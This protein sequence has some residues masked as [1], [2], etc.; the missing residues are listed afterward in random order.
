ML[1]M[2]YFPK[3]TPDPIRKTP[4]LCL[5]NQ[6]R[7]P[8]PPRTSFHAKKWAL[9]SQGNGVPA[10]CR[11]LWLGLLLW[12]ILTRRFHFVQSFSPLLKSYVLYAGI[13]LVYGWIRDVRRPHGIRLERLLPQPRVRKKAPNSG[14][15][16]LWLGLLPLLFVLRGSDWVL[17]YGFGTWILLE[18]PTVPKFFPFHP[19]PE[20]K[21][22]F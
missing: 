21:T 9:L 5:P 19:N 7:L 6:A 1:S 10:L 3:P 16:L 14:F 11:T 15:W 8:L 17:V 4:D 18:G 22:G 20:R 12:A 13:G 2:G